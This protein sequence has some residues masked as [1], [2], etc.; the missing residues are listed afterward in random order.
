MKV[1]VTGGAGFV[2][3]Y[4]VDRLIEDKHEVA[5][6]DDFSGG[7]MQNV[8]PHA[9]IYQADV[10]NPILVD[11]L[12][13]QFKPEM[14]FHLAA[15]AAENKAQFSPIDITTR[16]FGA[17][18]PVLTSAIKHK[19]KRFVFIS[20]AAV[21]GDI[22]LPHKETSIPKPE[23][24]YAISKYAFEESLKIMSK[25]H[26]IEYVIVR[27]HNI[28][29]PRQSMKDPYRNVVTIFMNKILRKE[30]HVIYGDGKQKRCFSYVEDVVGGIYKAGMGKKGKIYNIGSDDYYTINELSNA[31]IKASGTKIKPEYLPDRPQEVKVT[32]VD[33]S[34]AKKELNHECK[35][36]LEEGIKKTWEW[37]K[38]Q[39]PQEIVLTPLELESKKL[40]KNWKK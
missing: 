28:Y 4:I 38:K 3:S 5:I 16:N 35:T 30:P 20:S 11:S 12:F 17:S 36:T 26:G 40:P 39:G 23:D 8:N 25:V 18:I 15:N 34:L 9:K 1:L 13:R 2:G 24:L 7:T 29:G 10:R 14:V 22:K 27:P 19:A 31:I 37:A 33:H 21:Y 32:I 6:A